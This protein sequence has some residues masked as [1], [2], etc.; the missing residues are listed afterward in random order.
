MRMSR[1]FTRTTRQPPAEAE[2]V[3]HKLLVRAGYIKQLSAGIFSFLPLGLRSVRKI[4]S[5]VREEMDRIDG[6][7]ILMPVVV[8]GELWKES[9]RWDSVGEE[10]LRFKDRNDK[11]MVL[12]MTHEEPVTDIARRYLNSYRQ[13]PVMIY[14][15]QTKYRDEA[16]PRGGLIRVREFVMKDGY[17]F[18]ATTEDLD[19]YYEVVHRAYER[20]FHRCG[21][22]VTVV[23]SDPGMMGGKVAHEFMAVTPGGEDTLVLCSD[24]DYAAN[25]D[26][27]RAGRIESGEAPEE[28]RLE[29]TP[30]CVTVAQVCDYLSVTPDRLAK[31]VAYRD[32]GGTLY[33]VLVRGDLEVN[34]T[35]LQNYVG[36][37]LAYAG[38][39]DLEG[40]GFIPG[41]MSPVGVE[42]RPAVRVL[43]DRSVAAARNLVA[44]GNREGHH[45]VN[46]NFGRD[47]DGEP[48]DVVN[49][50]DGDR[51]AECGGELRVSRAIEVGNIFKLGTKYSEAMGATFTD[52]DGA[53]RPMVMG[54]YGIGIARI[55]AALVEKF[56]DDAGMNL[57]ISV[58][59]YEVHLVA[60]DW[61]S[62]DGVRRTAVE[63][64]HVLRGAGVEVLLDDRDESAGVKFK[65]AD[66]IGVPI[67]L[68]V[69][70]RTQAGGSVE[71]KLRG[72]DESTHVEIGEAADAVARI[73]GELMERVT[74]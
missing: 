71:I 9:G 72:E 62:N 33:M 29:S 19:R 14:H 40:A 44:G 54:C 64:Y 24:C 58:A 68:T 28:L 66:L 59:P 49:V 35:M 22:P 6:Q 36:A 23:Q 61:Q 17:S 38:D 26:V 45:Y 42:P 52:E 32:A 55:L 60:L 7:E 34:A 4:E 50:V 57:P 21:L 70:P 69:S 18:H 74:C 51:C 12:A 31:V 8:A 37:E 3:S 53:L 39:D 67:R 11:D 73:K 20:I 13:L 56:S 10:L 30:G 25:R 63:T 2:L 41:Y 65:D 5:I 47:F 46:V 27:A 15:I 1:L 43:V 16:R 48:V